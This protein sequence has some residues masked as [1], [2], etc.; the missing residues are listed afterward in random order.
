MSILTDIQDNVKQAMRDRDSE[1]STNLRLLVAAIQNEAK[2]K[3]VD[4]LPDDEAIK[5]LSRER[6]KSVDAAE[7]FE[8][9][10]APDRAAAEQRQIDLIDGYMPAQL[11]DDELGEIVGAAIDEAGASSMADM[12]AVM[13]V[14]MPKV[15]GR[16]DGKL[17][18]STVR[19]RLGAG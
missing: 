9:G 14:L 17:V 16:A 1:T 11:S 18:S 5:V 3:G 7:A 4:D 8:Q 13:K 2:D 12:G 6:K 15:Q 19:E 10:G